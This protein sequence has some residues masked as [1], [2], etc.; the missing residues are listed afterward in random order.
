MRAMA[1]L[2]ACMAMASSAAVHAQAR[3]QAPRAMRKSDTEPPKQRIVLDEADRAARVAEMKAWLGHLVGRFSFNGKVDIGEQAR[4]VRGMAVCNAIGG[5]SGVHC[6]VHGPNW[7]AAQGREPDTV[8]SIALPMLFFGFNPDTLEIQLV[9]IDPLQPGA[10]SG[11]LT[12]D[13][14]SLSTD[15]WN[16]CDRVPVS[17]CWTGGAVTARPE[18]EVIL[19]LLQTIRVRMAFQGSA[20]SNSRTQRYELHLRRLQNVP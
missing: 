12:D 8:N 7:A 3:G 16:V 10:R 1:A 15:I 2:L 14:V 13:K 19:E 4:D 5:G 20:V 17:T 9:L 11:A 6:V 18:G